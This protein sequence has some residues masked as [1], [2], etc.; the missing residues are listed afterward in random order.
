[1]VGSMTPKERQTKIRAEA[2]AKG[3]RQRIAWMT[4]PEWEAL[5]TLARNHGTTITSPQKR[6]ENVNRALL[7]KLQQIAGIRAT[8][9]Q[10]SLF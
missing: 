4:D 2:Q 1:M 7:K 6:I 5:Q 10:G 8:N 3:I 9:G